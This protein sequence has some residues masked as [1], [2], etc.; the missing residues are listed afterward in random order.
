MFDEWTQ[1]VLVQCTY[2]V[3]VFGFFTMGD[4]TLEGNAALSDCY[5]QLKW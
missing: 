5:L 1:I 4:A 2:R 3:N